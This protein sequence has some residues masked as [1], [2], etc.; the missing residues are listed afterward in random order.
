MRAGRNVARVLA[1]GIALLFVLALGSVGVAMAEPPPT[2]TSINPESGP[3]AGGTPVT[4]TG[5]GFVSPATVTIGS[6]A[7]GV[8]VISETEIKATTAVTTVGPVE[9]MVS[10]ENGT[11]TGGPQ[12]HL[13]RPPAE[14][15]KHHPEPGSDC[16]RHAGHDQGQRLP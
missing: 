11:S 4:I 8:E 10:D 3:T 6:A 12:I 9:V 13:Y 1:T 5:S 14:R 16:R 2:V 15:G 7:S